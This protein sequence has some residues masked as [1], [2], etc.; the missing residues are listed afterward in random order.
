MYIFYVPI[1]ILKTAIPRNDFNARY[2]EKQS[3]CS[4]GN[5]LLYE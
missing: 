1:P 2:D 5:L 4:S 3:L